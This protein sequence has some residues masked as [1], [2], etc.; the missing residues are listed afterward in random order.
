M[1]GYHAPSQHRTFA[2]K[3]NG[4]SRLLLERLHGGPLEMTAVSMHGAQRGMP[5][6]LS[7]RTGTPAQA[8]A[9]S[10]GAVPLHILASEEKAL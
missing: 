7:F 5:T 2:W 4:Y 9:G 10:L 8:W 3:T 1:W 6:A